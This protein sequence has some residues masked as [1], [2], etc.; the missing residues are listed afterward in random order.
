MVK[1][2]EESPRVVAAMIDKDPGIL[3]LHEKPAGSNLINAVAV[4]SPASVAN[5]LELVESPLPLA[6]VIV[7]LP[8]AICDRILQKLNGKHLTDLLRLT[9][10]TIEEGELRIYSLG[11]SE[12]VEFEALKLWNPTAGDSDSRSTAEAGAGQSECGAGALRAHA[13]AAHLMPTLPGTRNSEVASTS[14]STVTQQ[15]IIYTSAEK[16]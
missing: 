14:A 13:V 7:G 12:E 6:T 2:S 5:L 1:L 15:Q 3:E 11:V 9:Q 8:E 10:C 4:A 16:R